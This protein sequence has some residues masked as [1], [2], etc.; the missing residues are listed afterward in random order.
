MQP[1]QSEEVEVESAMTG[2]LFETA[3]DRDR[4][5]GLALDDGDGKRGLVA[6]DERDCRRQGTV[7]VGDGQDRLVGE[8]EVPRRTEMVERHGSRPQISGGTTW[9]AT[10]GRSRVAGEGPAASGEEWSWKESRGRHR[11]E[12]A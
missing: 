9:E 10:R 2:G 7:D 5:G 4:G 11:I 3:V 1:E 12:S 6:V 8:G